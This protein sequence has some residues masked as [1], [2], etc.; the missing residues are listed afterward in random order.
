MDLGDVLTFGGLALL[1]GALWM[2]DPWWVA[3]A[4]GAAICALGVRR[5][6]R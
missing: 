1:L 3:A 2:V 6:L 5:E 4:A